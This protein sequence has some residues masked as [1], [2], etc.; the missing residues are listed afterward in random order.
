MNVVVKLILFPA[1]FMAVMMLFA[2]GP[3]SGAPLPAGVNPFKVAFDG[4]NVWV[5]N[6][7]SNKVTK[8][9]ASDGAVQGTDGKLEPIGR[10][11]CSPLSAPHASSWRPF[12]Q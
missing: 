10:K 5:A 6:Y 4:T 3:A 7:S 11:N 2:G 9:R 12:A 8:L 1:I